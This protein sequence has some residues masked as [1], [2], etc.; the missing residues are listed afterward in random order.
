VGFDS[1]ER[2][3]AFRTFDSKFC[4]GCNN[5]RHHFQVFCDTC[6]EKLTVGV[7]K[8]LRNKASFVWA[9]WEAMKQLGHIQWARKVENKK[10]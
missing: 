7:L 6:E 4:A 1:Y 9:Y 5:R 3:I 2:E 10:K 8:G